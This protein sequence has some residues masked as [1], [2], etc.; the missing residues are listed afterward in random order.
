[1]EDIAINLVSTVVGV[2]AG[3]LV[4]L[5]F[6]KKAS[7]ETPEWAKEEFQNL[8]DK[9]PENPVS[10]EEL[11]RLIMENLP[12]YNNIQESGSNDDGEWI[13]FRD[14]TQVCKGKFSVRPEENK[15]DVVFPKDFLEE[16]SVDINGKN[17]KRIISKEATRSGLRIRVEMGD[18]ELD[19][20]TYHARGFWC[21]D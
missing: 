18:D 13:R 1:M 4:A 16:P 14:G 9:L 10:K 12:S 5:Y 2:V 20:F 15:A 6:H 11:S 17:V 8:A 7:V 3:Y 21:T 19:E